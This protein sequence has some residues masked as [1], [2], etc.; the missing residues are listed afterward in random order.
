VRHCQTTLAILAAL[1]ASIA[2][3]DD[4]KTIDGKEDKNVKVKRVEPD[5]IVLSTNYGISK[6]YFTELPKEVQERFHYDPAKA[7]AYS[8]QQ[9]QNLE[10][11]RKQQAHSQVQAQPQEARATA[12][13]V[14]PMATS[15]IETLPPIT[16]ALK[17][18]LLSAVKMTDELDALY[19]RGCT[20]AEFIAAT[21]PVE[22]VFMNLQ[23][24]LPKADPRHGLLVNAFDAYQQ[25][26]IA[27]KANEEGRGQRSDVTV[28]IATARLCKHLL[29]RILEGNLTPEE[30]S[31]YYAWRKGLRENP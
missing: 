31:V 6:V 7:A 12:A 16:V 28:T 17:D 13:A 19:K 5:G 29:R 4:F 27:M 11:W 20:S 10:A 1:S 3:A 15:D 9:N 2:L 14:E 25:T 22:P 23:K 26:A 8:T 30:K 18:E 21:L 24:K